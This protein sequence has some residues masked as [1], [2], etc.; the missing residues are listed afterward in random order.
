MTLF[1]SFYKTSLVY[2][3]KLTIWSHFS[4]N[5]L[6]IQF[7]FRKI[8]FKFISISKYCFSL[9]CCLIIMPLSCICTS[10]WINICSLSFPY[11]ILPISFICSAI[12]IFHFSKSIRFKIFKLSIIMCLFCIWINSRMWICS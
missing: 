12:S 11:S 9:T 10:I 4:I 7:I 8:T 6:T 2:F 3:Y 1:Y 5:S